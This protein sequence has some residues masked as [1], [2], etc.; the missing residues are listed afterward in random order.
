LLEKVKTWPGNCGPFVI[1]R[2][3]RVRRIEEKLAGVSRGTRWTSQSR[4]ESGKMGFAALA[5]AAW[6][7]GRKD[8]NDEA[9]KVAGRA[10]K[11]SQA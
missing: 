1:N 4:L 10:G 3:E 8:P 6:R 5:G 9:Y 2:Q 7:S 11:G